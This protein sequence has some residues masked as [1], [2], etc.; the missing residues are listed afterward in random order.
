MHPKTL[1]SFRAVGLKN[2]L[3]KSSYAKIQLE[4]VWRPRKLV[5]NTLVLFSTELT[6]LI[7]VSSDSKVVQNINKFRDIIEALPA[8]LI[9][10]GSFVHPN[11]CG[12][13]KLPFILPVREVL[14]S[15][16]SQSASTY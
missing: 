15:E 6:P 14:K 13:P 16:F 3:F 5:L 9:T 4:L 11:L 10:V 1:S 8:G 2:I 7:N 12:T